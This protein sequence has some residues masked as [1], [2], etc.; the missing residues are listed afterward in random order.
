[1]EKFYCNS[2]EKIRIDKNIS[3]ITYDLVLVL[4]ETPLS[5]NIVNMLAQGRTITSKGCLRIVYCENGAVAR[6]HAPMHFYKQT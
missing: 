6:Q 4:E 2:V 3:H 1:M 5:K